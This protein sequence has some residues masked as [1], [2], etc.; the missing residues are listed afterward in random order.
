MAVFGESAAA[1]DM[2]LQLVLTH[3]GL[4]ARKDDAAQ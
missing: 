2:F 1:A 3:S 4:A